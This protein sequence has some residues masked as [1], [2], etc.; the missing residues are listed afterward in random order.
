VSA[1]RCVFPIWEF[2]CQYG[3]IKIVCKHKKGIGLSPHNSLSK[4]AIYK[5]AWHLLRGE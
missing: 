1:L 3:E 5:E 2:S 4:H